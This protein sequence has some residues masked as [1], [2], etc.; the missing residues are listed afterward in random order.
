MMDADILARLQ[1]TV[2]SGFHWLF[3]LL[4]LGLAPIIAIMHTRHVL[5]GNLRFERMTRFWGQIYVVNYALGIATGLVMEFQFGLAWSGLTT[6]AGN[7]FGAPLAMET[8]VAFFAESTFLGMW[9]FGWGRLPKVLHMLLFWLVTLT[10]YASAYWIM[11][12]NGFMHRPVGHE[13]RDG[14]AYLTDFGALLTNSSAIN[15]MEHVVGAALLTG[16]AFVAGVSAYQFS[17]RTAEVDFFR[18]SLRLGL[19]FAVPFGIATVEAGFRQ[20]PDLNVAQPMK[21]AVLRDFLQPEDRGPYTVEQVQSMM[22]QQY[23]PGDYAPPAWIGSAYDF[24]TITAFFIVVISLF[25]AGFLI[26][27]HIVR[28]R[29][30]ALMVTVIIPLPFIAATLGWLVREV[31]RQPWTIYGEL[32]TSQ[33]RSS[34]SAGTMLASL[35]GFTALLAGLAVTNWILIGR[36]ARRGPRE[37]DLGSPGPRVDPEPVM[38]L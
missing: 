29:G 2:T 10:A 27:D 26:R 37:T 33:A 9:I 24:M 30:A 21:M 15:A 19:L 18:S 3:V 1:F 32:L 36:Y 38:A 20:F 35:I 11:V 7:V 12:A 13:V 14:V 34:V 22:V 17:R 16:G 4:T 23:G 8:L 6:F 31:G 25:G 28:S 5:T